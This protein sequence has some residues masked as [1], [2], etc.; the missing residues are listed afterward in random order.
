MAEVEYGPPPLLALVAGD[1][2]R[3]DLAG[4]GHQVRQRAA[5]AAEYLVQATLNIGEKAGVCN[6][7]ILDHFRHARTQ[8]PVGQAAQRI[9]AG[10]HEQGLVERADQVLPAPVVDGD[11]AP[12]A[13]V[14]LG[15]QGS[16]DLN[17]R[18]AAQEGGRGETGQVSDDPAAQ[19]DDGGTAVH[20][21]S[22]HGVVELSGPLQRL[23]L[24]AVRHLDQVRFESGCS[25]GI[26]RPFSIALRDARVGHDQ[27][28]AGQ[29]E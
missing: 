27:R 9:Q 20:A 2:F 6:D 4:T 16:G 11:L 21:V 19:R 17:E 7:P 26:R 10:E 5:V 28:A 15:E 23:L 22:Q 8:F 18:D 1:H 29:V 12:H 25:Q 3:L 14:H 13:R 24:L